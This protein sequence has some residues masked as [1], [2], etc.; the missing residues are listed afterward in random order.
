MS[1][2]ADVEFRIRNNQISGTLP[3]SWQYMPITHLDVGEN[4]L[5]GDLSLIKNMVL[6][7]EFRM[8]SKCALSA[9]L[10]CEGGGGVMC[11]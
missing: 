9:P 1:H 7:L 5:V 11:L 4:N 10:C 3:P 6:V 2:P 8:D